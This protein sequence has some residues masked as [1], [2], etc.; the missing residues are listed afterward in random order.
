M[1][2]HA[3]EIAKR[4]TAAELAALFALVRQTPAFIA[5]KEGRYERR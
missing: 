5:W 3:T 2:L 1:K 4:R